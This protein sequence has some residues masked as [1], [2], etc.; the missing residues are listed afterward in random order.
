MLEGT[1]H[2]EPGSESGSARALPV[3]P[4]AGQ[5]TYEQGGSERQR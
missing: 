4:A 5:G 2:R 1:K 3:D